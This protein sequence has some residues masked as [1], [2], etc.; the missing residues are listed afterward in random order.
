MFIGSLSHILPGN[1]SGIPLLTQQEGPLR[2]RTA[3]RRA[4]NETMDCT[5]VSLEQGIPAGLLGRTLARFLFALASL[6]LLFCLVKKAQHCG[7]CLSCTA[8][9]LTLLCAPQEC[10]QNAQ[11]IIR[12]GCCQASQQGQL[13]RLSLTVTYWSGTSVCLLSCRLVQDCCRTR[14]CGQLLC[15]RHWSCRAASPE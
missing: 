5:S 6:A 12:G 11:I 7:P 3:L 14:Q 2:A 4:N 15:C 8:R 1:P 10:R 9:L 13:S